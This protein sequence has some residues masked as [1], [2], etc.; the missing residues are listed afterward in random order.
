MKIIST[1]LLAVTMLTSLGFQPVSE[2]K[3]L[4][5]STDSSGRYLLLAYE[6]TGIYDY[7][8]IT[9]GTEEG[10]TTQSDMLPGKPMGFSISG[11]GH[12]VTVAVETVT[13]IYV[14]KIE[15]VVS[16][17][18]GISNTVYIPIIAK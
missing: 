2:G 16:I 7:L 5:L 11:C 17:P 14:E 4:W 3:T 1:L 13:T 15:T 10:S 6:D 18:C 8:V 12:F 9:E